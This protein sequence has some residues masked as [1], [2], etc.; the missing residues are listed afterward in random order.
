[1]RNEVGAGR[2]GTRPGT[3]DGDLV[4]FVAATDGDGP[5]RSRLRLEAAMSGGEAGERAR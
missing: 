3:V 5:V 4:P 2:A 1:V